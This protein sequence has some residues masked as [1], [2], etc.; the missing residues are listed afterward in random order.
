MKRQE[1]NSTLTMIH[2]GFLA[3]GLYLVRISDRSG[4]PFSSRLLIY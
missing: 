1:L 3:E 2:T 4:K